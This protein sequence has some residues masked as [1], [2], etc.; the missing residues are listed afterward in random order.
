MKIRN[1]DKIIIN[2]IAEIIIIDLINNKIKAGEDKEEIIKKMR[3]QGI[4][5]KKMLKK[6]RINY[7][8]IQ[9]FHIKIENKEKHIIIETETE[10]KRLKI[11]KNL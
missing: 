11:I 8:K 7:K 1:K 9:K 3:N 2:K 6:N 5:Q 4:N 10:M